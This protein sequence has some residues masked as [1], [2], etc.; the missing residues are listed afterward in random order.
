MRFDWVRLN[1]PAGSLSALDDFYVGRLGFEQE[2]GLKIGETQLVFEAR[3]GEPFYHFALLVPGDR[4]E[5]AL[6]WID[7]R[8]ELL[9]DRETGEVVFDFTNWDA[10]A[11]YFHDPFGNIVE[12]IAHRGIEE[13]ATNGRFTAAELV[14]FSELG[15]VG[16]KADLASAL[17]SDLS[18]EQWDGE[19]LEEGR[20]AFVGEKAR[21][22]I[23]SSDGRGWLPTGRPAEPHPCEVLLADAPGSGTRQFSW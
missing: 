2:S 12:L 6:H 5:A 8:V 1:A 16:D 17:R 3:S 20:L 21:T 13:S 11:C 7:D 9:P 23:L 19:L 22:F 10:F 4:F 15:L 14:G 18:L